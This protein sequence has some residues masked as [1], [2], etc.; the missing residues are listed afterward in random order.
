MTL[1]HC[2]EVIPYSGFRRSTM[3]TVAATN[4]FERRRLAL[5]KL[6][7]AKFSWYHVRYPL[8]PSVADFGS[9]IIVAGV[10]L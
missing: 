7:N 1:P 8:F 10:G 6:D 5:E 9:A 2:F 3:D 4:A